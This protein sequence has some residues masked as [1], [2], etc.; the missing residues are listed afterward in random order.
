MNE[1]KGGLSGVKKV[2]QSRSPFRWLWVLMVFAEIYQVSSTLVRL[3]RA[4][5]RFFLTGLASLLD[6]PTYRLSQRPAS[7]TPPATQL[8]SRDQRVAPRAS[9][10]R[11]R[12]AAQ[13]PRLCFG[14]H[15]SRLRML[16][17]KLGI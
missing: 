12:L 9:G 17:A 16:H 11:A 8:I 15:G 1:L 3:V 6:V 7:S 10:H 14:S 2:V 5:A 4:P 13:R